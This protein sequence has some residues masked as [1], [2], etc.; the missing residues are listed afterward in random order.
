M[1]SPCLA[2]TFGQTVARLPGL[3]DHPPTHQ[4]GHVL[5]ADLCHH[6]V[7]GR[8]QGHVS[9]VGQTGDQ[10]GPGGCAILAADDRCLLYTSRC[11]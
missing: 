5:R 8:G 10:G 9:A 3:H 1:V 7:V 11:V 2:S 6:R 4:P